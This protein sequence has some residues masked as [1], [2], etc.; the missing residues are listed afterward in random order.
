MW[1][2]WTNRENVDVTTVVELN[3][4]FYYLYW[5]YVPRKEVQFTI[6]KGRYFNHYI[7]L[8]LQ[9]VGC[10]VFDRYFG[11]PAEIE[12]HYRKGLALKKAIIK[13]SSKWKRRL[14]KNCTR[15]DLQRA[16]RDFKEEFRIVNHVYSITSF[17]SIEAWQE[18]YWQ[19][20]TKLIA[21]N[22]SQFNYEKVLFSLNR[23]L[24]KTATAQ[25][26]E[27][28]KHGVAVSRLVDKYQFLRSWSIVWYRPI[29]KDWI[30]SLK[31]KK[32]NKL[33]AYSYKELCLLLRP[34]KEEKKHIRIAPYVAFFKDWRDDFRRFQVYS[35]AFLF[36]NIAKFLKMRTDDL[37]YL[38][39]DEINLAIKKGVIDHNLVRTRK[40]GCIV[41][42]SKTGP[43]MRVVCGKRMRRYMKIIKK[44]ADSEKGIKIK[45]LIA[46]KGRAT[47]KVVVM[48]TFDDMKKVTPG[49][50]LVVNTTHSNYLPAMQK[51]AAF[52]TNEGGIISHAAIVARELKKPCIVN[53]KVATKVLNN[54]DIVE[55]DANKGIVRKLR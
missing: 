24:R 26:Q 9:S 31:V 55:V 6:C 38:S 54:G 48:N 44:I 3:R 41:T 5:D 22:N 32:P 28:M 15:A 1:T 19:R 18:D 21:R 27:E 51:A 46:Q 37:G 43:E 17:L 10:K 53:T 13:S 2:K 16:L 50:I 29:D 33:A 11:A 49:C 40:K 14:L 7:N 23:P 8:D 35:W 36:E 52:V 4:Q 42:C 30:T 45:G 20:M 47:G 25:L 34:T 39:L 12:K